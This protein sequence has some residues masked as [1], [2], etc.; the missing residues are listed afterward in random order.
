MPRGNKTF[1]QRPENEYVE[2]SGQEL[3]KR[4]G[5]NLEIP[6]RNTEVPIVPVAVAPQTT[7]IGVAMASVSADG[8]PQRSFRF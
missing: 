6:I 1:D 4:D 5:D 8:K 7:G 2:A 3:E